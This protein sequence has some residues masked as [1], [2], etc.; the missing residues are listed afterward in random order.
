MTRLLVVDA[1]NTNLVLGYYRGDELEA[2]WR[3]ATSLDRTVDE[4][5][6]M[7][8]QLV[9]QKADEPFEGAIVSSVVP[10]IDHVI[11]AMIRRYFGV[12]PLFVRPGVKT[13]LA[14]K[15]ENPMEVGADRVANAVAAHHIH[16]G[17]TIVV[18]FGTAT[19]F[20][21]V[22]AAGE[23]MGG[24]IAPGVMVAAEGLFSRAARLPRVEIRRP[25]QLIGTNTVSSM[26]SGIYFGYLELVDGILERMIDEIG[27]VKTVLA[28]GGV[29]PMIAK[30]SELIETIDPDL[31]LRGLK[32]IWDRNRVRKDRGR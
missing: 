23:Y 27:T 7:A 24:I 14:V 31:T 29:A 5:G 18:D 12:E 16:G 3:L 13:G 30:D 19:T 15:T 8:S 4:Y 1:G 28:T 2:S 32:I 25:D 11:D 20:D 9:L 10:H 17:P 21:L 26:Q 22:S 6:I